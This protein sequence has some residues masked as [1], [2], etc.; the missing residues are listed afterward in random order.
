MLATLY[1]E[2][3]AQEKDAAARQALLGRAITA[4]TRTIEERRHQ[5]ACSRRA[6]RHADGGREHR[7]GGQVVPGC[8]FCEPENVGSG[9][10]GRT[11]SRNQKVSGHERA[12]RAKALAGD[13]HHHA[14]HPRGR[15]RRVH[16]WRFARESASASGSDRS[17]S[18]STVCAP[19]AFPRTV[20]PAGATPNIDHLAARGIV[21]ERAYTHSPQTLPAHA[22][23]VT[24]QLPFDNG[25]RDEG[26]LR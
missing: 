6:G 13:C 10:S 5:R 25:V 16:G 12:G 3:A 18:P 22:A 19:I 9:R 14:V 21:F 2:K 4:Y 24:G 17:R 1:R 26:G 20:G 11:S 15:R 23:L 8:D 7:G